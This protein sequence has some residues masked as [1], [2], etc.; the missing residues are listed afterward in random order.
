MVVIIIYILTWNISMKN[1][2][3]SKLEDQKKGIKT[4]QTH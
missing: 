4:K 1:S 2:Y 3:A